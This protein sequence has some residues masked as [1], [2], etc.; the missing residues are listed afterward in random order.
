MNSATQSL[1][2]ANSR[3]S[4]AIFDLFLQLEDG[5]G[6]RRRDAIQAPIA[7]S[8]Q[9]LAWIWVLIMAYLPLHGSM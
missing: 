3:H 7:D 6:K 2:S 1:T 9:L 5:C 8:T 4:A